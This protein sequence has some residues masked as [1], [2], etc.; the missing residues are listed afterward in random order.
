MELYDCIKSIDCG[1]DKEPLWRISSF[2]LIFDNAKAAEQE[3][4]KGIDPHR[5]YRVIFTVLRSTH[6]LTDTVSI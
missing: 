2:S 6:Q 1:R 3:R 4:Q 5:K